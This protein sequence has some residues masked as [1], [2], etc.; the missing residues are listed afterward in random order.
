VTGP[1]KA[2]DFRAEHVLA[3]YQLM[4]EN[5]IYPPGLALLGAFNTYSRYA[6]PREAVF[7]AL[8]RKNMGCSHF[9][10]GRDHTGVGDF[11]PV[12]GNRRMFESLGD[13]GITPVFFDAVGYNSQTEAYEESATADGLI[14]ISGTQVRDMLRAREDFPTWFMRDEVQNMLRQR[15]NSG[16]ELFH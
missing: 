2:N 1:K 9:V 4:L 12:D 15:I 13:L 6:G 10:I 8:C 11:Y 14:N 7:T 16:T 5:G 3:S